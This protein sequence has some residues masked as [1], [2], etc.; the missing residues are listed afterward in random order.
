MICEEAVLAIKR[1][2]KAAAAFAEP[3]SSDLGPRHTG[4]GAD[5][6]QA[7]A[8]VLV[9]LFQTHL[10]ADALVI[11]AGAGRQVAGLAAAGD[12]PQAWPGRRAHKALGGGWE[13]FQDI[14]PIPMLEPAVVATF[15]RLSSGRQ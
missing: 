8:P 7:P 3:A 4:A 2:G 1:T 11:R 14:P 10:V 15:R 13:L 6:F 12:E 9:S 5:P